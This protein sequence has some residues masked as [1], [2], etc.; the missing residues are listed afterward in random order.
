MSTF[1]EDI[2]AE[3]YKKHGEGLSNMTVVLPSRRSGLFFRY[4]LAPHLERPMWMP[5]I[6]SIEEFVANLSGKETVDS[7]SLLFEFYTA[8]VSVE[9][10]KAEPFE[11]FAQWAEVLLHDFNEVDR[12]LIEPNY[13]F[14]YLKEAKKLEKWTLNIPDKNSTPLMENYMRFWEQMGKYYHAL[15]AHLLEQDKI[16]QGLSYRLVCN[17]IKE[18]KEAWLDRLDT[19]NIIFLGLNALN[20]AEEEIIQ[21]LLKNKKAEIHWDADAYYVK[22]GKQEAGLFLRK[23]FNTWPLLKG[24]K[25]N[26]STHFS[27]DLKEIQ[28][29]GVSGNIAQAKL[30]GQL[31]QS[32]ELKH[33]TPEQ[34]A[35]VL[36]DEQLLLPMLQS[37]PEHIDKVNVTMGYPL[38]YVPQTAFFE[39][40]FKMKTNAQKYQSEGKAYAYYHKDVLS[41]VSH[42]YTQVILGDTLAFSLEVKN[43]NKI[44]L[45]PKQLQEAFPENPFAKI[46]FADWNE[47]AEA[48]LN[49]TIRLIDFLGAYFTDNPLLAGAALEREYLMH[50]SKVFKRL[51]TLQ[52]KYGHLNDIKTLLY[53]F[54]QLLQQESLDFYGEPLEGLQIMG[55]LE[56][57]ALDF[58]TL[59]MTSVNEGVLPSGKTNSSLIPYDIKKEVGLPTFYEKDAVYAYHFY[60]I[61]QRAKKVYLIYNTQQEVF[62]GG[63][64]SRFITQLQEELARLHPQSIKFTETV[65]A[66]D[67]PKNKPAAIVKIKTPGVIERLN[68][69]AIK[70]FSPTSLST[71]IQCPL[72]FYYER[73]VQLR[74]DEEVEESIDARTL[75]TVVHETLEVLYTP[76]AASKTLLLEQDLKS[77]I[78]RIKDEVEKQFAKAYPNGNMKEGHN[79]LLFTVACTYVKKL[80]QFDI[81]EIQSGKELIITGLERELVKHI[82]AA[83][84][85]IK[86]YGKAD[87]QDQLNGLDRIIDYKTGGVVKAQV[88]VKEMAELI[89]NPGKRYAF[90]LACYNYMLDSEKQQEAGI[91]SFKNMNEGVLGFYCKEDGFEAFETELQGLFETLFNPEIPFEQTKDEKNCLYCDFKE[92][93]GR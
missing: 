55:V 3:L 56:T 31:L 9:G 2:A 32:E 25:P 51:L 52:E 89:A 65:Y 71:L 44:F 38:K 83:G 93:C 70:G 42:A 10:A 5:E 1:L 26:L 30:A 29:I 73:I 13:I 7:L 80:I 23:H 72:K 16:Y 39:L 61:L 85:D 57:R 76:F 78:P 8:Y 54:R 59:I 17:D 66:S 49:D 15:G 36:A 90:Q 50:F 6:V 14:S 20:K 12:Y 88:K 27:S 77:L 84:K 79:L 34:T 53:L 41:L 21:F 81:N 35:L 75:G 82:N 24:K 4:A 68:Q 22:N 28:A 67:L 47:N 86:L 60:R 92:I 63:E 69:I 19:E 33:K 62:G 74:E 87:R 37:V 91:I 48:A 46:L 58:E 64:K 18:E 43:K 45:T 11:K 40:L